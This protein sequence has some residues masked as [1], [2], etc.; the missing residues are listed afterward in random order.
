MPFVTLCSG[1]ASL[2]SK[3]T[4]GVRLVRLLFESFKDRAMKMPRLG[5][6]PVPRLQQKMSRK[7]MDLS[8]GRGMNGDYAGDMHA[9][10]LNGLRS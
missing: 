2:Y 8:M 6:Y 9:S 3:G 7:A 1:I 10:Q 5:E 4:K